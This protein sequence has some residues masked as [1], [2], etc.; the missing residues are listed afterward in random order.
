MFDEIALKIS[1]RLV[2][3]QH[4]YRQYRLVERLFIILPLMH[5]E[6]IEDCEMS[7]ALIQGNIEYAE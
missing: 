6:R 7:L 2:A 3:R 1:K 5:S 4:E